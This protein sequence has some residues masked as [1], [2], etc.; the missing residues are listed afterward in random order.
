MASKKLRKQIV[1]FIWW[2]DITTSIIIMMSIKMAIW[3]IY[4]QT[5]AIIKTI[6]VEISIYMMCR[7]STT[8]PR[9]IILKAKTF[10]TKSATTLLPLKRLIFYR[11]I[12]GKSTHANIIA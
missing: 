11:V 1:I 10:T 5:C 3:V 9:L 8:R 4:T 12:N 2:Y 7:P 6:I